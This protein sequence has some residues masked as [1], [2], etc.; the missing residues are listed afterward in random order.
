MNLGTPKKL[1]HS[2]SA[3]SS[4]PKP[5]FLPEP[6]SFSTKKV[7]VNGILKLKKSQ[8]KMQ[9]FLGG[10]RRLS[11][12]SCADAS[13][14]SRKCSK[15]HIFTREYTQYT[16]GSTFCFVLLVFVVLGNQPL[17]NGATCSF[18][19]LL[20]LVRQTCPAILPCSL[21]RK[22]CPAV[23]PGSLA[24]QSCPAVLPGSLARQ[25]CPAVLPDSLAR[26]SCL[27]I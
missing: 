13:E 10:R 19:D 27:A 11:T 22:S 2:I 1:V 7:R 12:E 21:A 9:H 4:L 18:C 25:S 26:Q 6:K 17:V 3:P 14:M 23:L 20:S 15:K 5:T 24:R 16:S 8:K